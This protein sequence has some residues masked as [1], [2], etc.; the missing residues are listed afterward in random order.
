MCSK[1][2]KKHLNKFTKEKNCKAKKNIKGFIDIEYNRCPTF[3]KIVMWWKKYIIFLKS[4][5]T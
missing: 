1:K 5:E 2:E 3:W 4:V